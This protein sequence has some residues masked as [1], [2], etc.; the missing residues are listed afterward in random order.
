MRSRPSEK[1]R[2]AAR[3][4]I[5]CREVLDPVFCGVLDVVTNERLDL[6][7]DL[8]YT[9]APVDALQLLYSNWL[10]LLQLRPLAESNRFRAHTCRN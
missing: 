6:I 8:L 2:V 10:S 3:Q 1:N 5:G 7:K 9:L 4:G